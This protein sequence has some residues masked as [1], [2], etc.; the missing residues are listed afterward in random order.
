MKALLGFNPLHRVRY[1]ASSMSK[2]LRLKKK[3]VSI[4]FI[5]SG[6]PQETPFLARTTT[7]FEG[8]DYT[9]VRKKAKP[10]CKFVQ[11][12]AQTRMYIEPP[13]SIFQQSATKPVSARV[14]GSFFTSFFHFV[15]PPRILVNFA[16]YTFIITLLSFCV[17]KKINPPHLP[18]SFSSLL[19]A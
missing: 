1:S 18:P 6:T 16:G 19:V 15:R 3:S 17:K 14:K 9:G 12:I 2:L 13:G 11:K 7:G 8:C 4:P 5:G 10:P